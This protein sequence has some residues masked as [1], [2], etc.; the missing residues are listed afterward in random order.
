MVSDERFTG[1]TIY[2]G[3]LKRNEYF[4]FYENGMRISEKEVLKNLNSQSGAILGYDKLVSDL[5]KENEQLE[6]GKMEALSLLGEEIDK[7]EQL[8]SYKLYSDNK[9][10]QTIIADLKKENE[11]LRH[12][13]ETEKK[14]QLEKSQYY[15]KIKEENEMLKSE[16]KKLHCINDQ[17]EERLENS[18]IGI[19]LK[20][21]CGNNE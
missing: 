21:D 15:I 6:K 8:K 19:V 17:L 9:R 14:W 16:N 2:A 4:Q 18:G 1:H 10:L 3:G 13:I 7:N 5:R 12:E 20:M 11:Q